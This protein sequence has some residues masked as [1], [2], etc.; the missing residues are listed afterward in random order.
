MR[1]LVLVRPGLYPVISPQG[2]PMVNQRS[3]LLG[4]FVEPKN[5][6]Y[7]SEIKKTQPFQTSETEMVD[8]IKVTKS[9][10]EP[11]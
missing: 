2:G 6:S 10:H 7:P 3:Q 4:I 1:P 5:V 8:S 9:H 11:T